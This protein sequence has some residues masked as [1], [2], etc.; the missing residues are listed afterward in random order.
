VRASIQRSN[1]FS[2]PTSRPPSFRMN[3][4]NP[5]SHLRNTVSQNT[6]VALLFLVMEE[7]D[8]FGQFPG[9]R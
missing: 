8:H 1:P 6:I 2:D 9:L 7:A 3:G 5:A 4:Y